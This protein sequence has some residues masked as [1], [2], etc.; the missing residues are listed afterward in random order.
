MT[1]KSTSLYVVC[2]EG[3]G[4]KSRHWD[5]SSHAGINIFDNFESA[6]AAVIQFVNEYGTKTAITN[7][8]KR[9]YGATYF[10][11]YFGQT[12][13]GP[14]KNPYV[15]NIKQV[16]RIIATKTHKL[17]DIEKE[18]VGS[19]PISIKKNLWLRISA[20]GINNTTL[21]R[22]YYDDM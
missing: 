9:S 8:Y 11:G 18:L 20:N 2:I 12:V 13:M 3:L 15:E 1:K 10:C 21:A 22:N 14:R 7:L 16:D 4:A 5:E 19:G 6:W 17:D